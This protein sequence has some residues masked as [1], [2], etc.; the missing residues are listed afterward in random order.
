MATGG[1][2]NPFRRYIQPSYSVL[3]PHDTGPFEL[4]CLGTN[5]GHIQPASWVPSRPTPGDRGWFRQSRVGWQVRALPAALD[6]ASTPFCLGGLGGFDPALL[7]SDPLHYFAFSSSSSGLPRPSWVSLFDFLSFLRFLR[8]FLLL[9]L[10]HLRP[11]LMS[12]FSRLQ[13][14]LQIYLALSFKLSF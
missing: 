13:L 6:G 7:M 10:S 4:P 8:R 2:S 12:R 9:R 5:P 14:H 3:H 1:R 11:S